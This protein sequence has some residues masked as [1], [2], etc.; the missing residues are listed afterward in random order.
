MVYVG[1]KKPPFQKFTGIH[2][3][4]GAPFMGFIGNGG[5]FRP[6]GGGI[7]NV[8][9]VPVP[10]LNRDTELSPEALAI[11]QKISGDNNEYQ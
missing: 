1:L 5:P 2:R 8:A 9:G 10:F 11:S 3:P 4:F 7:L 6:R